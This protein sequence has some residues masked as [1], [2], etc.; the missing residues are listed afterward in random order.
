DQPDRG[1]GHDQQQRQQEQLQSPDR[2]AAYGF[3]RGRR[4]PTRRTFGL[5]TGFFDRHRARLSLPGLGAFAAGPP[6]RPLDGV[7][8]LLLRRRGAVVVGGRGG[9]DRL[10]RGGV[11]DR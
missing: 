4:P 2:S 5:A 1:G 10:G 9:F 6:A 3:G 11:A 7:V 8:G